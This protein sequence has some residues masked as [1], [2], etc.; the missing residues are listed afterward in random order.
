M[1]DIIFKIAC[2]EPWKVISHGD[3]WTSN[4]LFR[5]DST[6][7]QPLEVI[8]VDQQLVHETCIVNDL[9][10]AIY[11]STDLKFRKNHLNDLLSI[12]YNEFNRICTTLKVPTLPGFSEKELS[13]RFHRA[14]LFAFFI[15]VAE[16]PFVLK[17]QAELSDL[18]KVEVG[19]TASDMMM[20]IC[21]G[22]KGNQLLRSRLLEL[23]QELF[24]DGII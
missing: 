2:T 7:G 22:F 17:N 11:I 12:Y 1:H 5:Y 8:M 18:E 16:L 13:K 23:G 9:I 15:S 6:T 20:D 24:D 14:K 10:H 3:C 19:K 21:Q 4:L